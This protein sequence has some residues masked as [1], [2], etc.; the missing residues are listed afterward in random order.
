[1]LLSITTAVGLFGAALMFCGDM[2]LYFTAKPFEL[3]GTMKPYIA[4]MKLIPDWRLTLGGLLGPIAAFFYCV[5]FCQMALA[6]TEAYRAFGVAA[7]G[8]CSLGIIVGGAYHAQFSY[9][10]LIGKHDEA[11]LTPVLKNVRLLSMVSMALIAA[12]VL[13]FGGMLVL[14]TTCYPRW[15]VLCSPV[16]LFFLGRLWVKAPQPFRIVLLG[17]WYNLMFVYYFLCALLLAC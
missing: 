17:G 4:I 3:D 6:A 14:G 15:L 16:V 13:V 5:G 9:F 2:L 1:M 11:A 10:G 12:G 7:A 8:L